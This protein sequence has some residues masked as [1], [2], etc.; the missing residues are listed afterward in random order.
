MLYDLDIIAK[1]KEPSKNINRK[2][3]VIQALEDYINR[4]ENRKTCRQK[5]RA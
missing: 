5:S 2:D 3:S 4:H 1:R